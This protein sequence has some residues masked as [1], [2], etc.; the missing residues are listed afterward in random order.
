MDQT[1]RRASGPRVAAT[2]LSAS[3]K[4]AIADHWALL[5]AR[6]DQLRL[7]AMFERA[8][9]AVRFGATPRAVLGTGGNAWVDPVIHSGERA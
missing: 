6:R 1:P 2:H 7:Q 4:A 5:K 8:M 9:R 3:G